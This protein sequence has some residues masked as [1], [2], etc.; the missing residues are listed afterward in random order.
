MSYLNLI[1]DIQTIFDKMLAHHEAVQRLLMTDAKKM[2]KNPDDAFVNKSSYNIW[3]LNFTSL[4]E[5]KVIFPMIESTAIYIVTY[6]VFE[7]I[8]KKIC[9]E[10]VNLIQREFPV[11]EGGGESKILCF[12]CSEGLN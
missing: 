8:L 7:D 6:N 10:L 5:L 3:G 9:Q 4:R 1:S 2:E 11:C 12:P